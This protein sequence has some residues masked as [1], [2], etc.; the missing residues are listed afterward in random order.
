MVD[1]WPWDYIF[2][3]ESATL[4][5]TVT[6]ELDESLILRIG[7]AP[8]WQSRHLQP[9]PASWRGLPGGDAVSHG[10]V[11]QVCADLHSAIFMAH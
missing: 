1:A 6:S 4:W 8:V 11:L 2:L 9:S 7:S 3:K 5:L 10:N